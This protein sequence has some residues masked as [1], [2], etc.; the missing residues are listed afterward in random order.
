MNTRAAF[1]KRGKNANIQKNRMHILK[2]GA[3]TAQRFVD[4]LIKESKRK[5]NN[6]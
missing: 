3:I 5:K 1:M 2:S 6:V 4:I